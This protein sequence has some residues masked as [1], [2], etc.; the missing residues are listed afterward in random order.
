MGASSVISPTLFK[1]PGRSS[2]SP[3]AET[4]SEHRTSSFCWWT[5]ESQSPQT[6][7]VSNRLLFYFIHYILLI[8][9]INKLMKRRYAQLGYGK[10]KTSVILRSDSPVHGFGDKFP[11][12]WKSFCWLYFDF[13]FV[14]LHYLLC[15]YQRSHSASF[16]EYSFVVSGGSIEADEL[17]PLITRMLVHCNTV[18]FIIR[19]LSNNYYDD[20]MLIHRFYTAPLNPWMYIVRWKKLV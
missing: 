20:I 2:S 10:R 19:I 18:V 17:H 8:R 4:A 13:V 3:T 16:Y 7:S 11:R 1:S 9:T 12:S 14:L 6:P 5:A 15:L